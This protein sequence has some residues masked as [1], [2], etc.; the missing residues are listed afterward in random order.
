[1]IGTRS[2]S[3]FSK[4]TKYFRQVSE[5]SRLRNDIYISTDDFVKGISIFFAYRYRSYGTYSLIWR[6]VSGY[7][8]PIQL[9]VSFLRIYNWFSRGMAELMIITS[10]GSR[11]YKPTTY[12]RQ[13]GEGSRLRNDIYIP[14]D[15][16][17]KGISILFAFGHRFY[18]IYALI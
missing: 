17:V 3:R 12:F 18:G 5:G 8:A 11:F 10:S 1:M 15:D 14:T 4:P 16:F 2:G 9:R 13:G 7:E 6:G